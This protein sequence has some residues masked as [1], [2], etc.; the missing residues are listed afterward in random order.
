MLNL[1]V[2]EKLQSTITMFS[3][4]FEIFNWFRKLWERLDEKTKRAIIEEVVKSFEEL[5]RSFY[6][7][8]KNR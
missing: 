5:L 7:W 4:L 2:F 6:K 8:W 1:A 3:W